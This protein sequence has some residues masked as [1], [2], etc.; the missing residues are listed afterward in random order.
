MNVFVIFGQEGC[1]LDDIMETIY[2]VCGK[3]LKSLYNIERLKPT[4]SLTIDGSKYISIDNNIFSNRYF[5]RD[6]N[7]VYTSKDFPDEIS[8]FAIPKINGKVSRYGINDIYIYGD[9]NLY[10]KLVD[11]YSG[12][13]GDDY[14]NVNVYPIFIHRDIK[15]R[16]DA[17]I[18]KIDE[19]EEGQLYDVIT[20]F[21]RGE[22]YKYYR[23]M[24]QT[25]F[26]DKHEGENIEDYII[27]NKSESSDLK[28][29]K[30]RKVIIEII[31]VLLKHK[32]IYD[33]K[34]SELYPVI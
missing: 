27:T 32:K 8:K 4:T 14:E 16:L 33:Y 30:Y 19:N 7:T 10:K 5:D 12:C 21:S 24:I 2:E 28:D 26:I 20:K 25:T 13:E 22:Q 23:D 31:K 17:T 15:N 29:T 6:E 1:G 9:E 34:D 3:M 11:Q 18:S